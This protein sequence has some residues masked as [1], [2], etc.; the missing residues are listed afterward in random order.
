MLFAKLLHILASGIWLGTAMTLPFWGNR[1]NR[2]DNLPMVLG[3]GDTVFLL[4]NIFIMGGLAVTL[5]TGIYL[6]QAAG[7]GYFAFDGPLSWL[8]Y[9]QLLFLVIAFNSVLILYLMI[10]G[11]QGRRSHFRW[12]PPIGYNNIALIILLFAQMTLRPGAED[13]A[14]YLGLPLLAILLADAG[15]FLRRRRLV[16][17][18]RALSP[19]DFVQRYFDLLEREDMTNFFRQFRD[20]AEFHDPFATHPVIGLKNIEKFFQQLGDQFEH[21]SIKPEQVYGT[22]ERM[23]TVWTASGT[24]KNGER[25]APFSGVNMMERVRGKISKVQIHF[26]PRQL[27]RVTRVTLDRA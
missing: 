2:A 16:R 19:Q 5:L 8:G 15:Y 13:Q 20:D 7:Y 18:I 1:I 23:V 17:R 21:I 22:P 9:S 4:K 27:P 26:D 6:T 12:V 3:I 24:T 11:R 14:L 25:F 10:R